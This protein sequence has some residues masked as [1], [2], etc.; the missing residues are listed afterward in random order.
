MLSEQA[1]SLNDP[2]TTSWQNWFRPTN[3]FPARVFGSIVGSLGPEHSSVSPLVCIG[4]PREADGFDI[5]SVAINEH[6]L[7]CS[8]ELCELAALTRGRPFVVAEDLDGDDVGLQ[9]VD[10]LYATVGLRRYRRVW[11]ARTPGSDRLAGAA[12]AYRGPL[13]LN[14]SFLENRCDLLLDP[15]LNPLQTATVARALAGAAAVAYTDFPLARTPTTTD[16]RTAA[17]LVDAGCELIRPYVQSV[18]LRDGAWAWYEH[19]DSFYSRIMRA[20]RRRGLGASVPSQAPTE[21]GPA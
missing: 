15:D 18:W 6:T 14:L 8:G 10:S 9:E 2:S 21:A 12:L 13:G 11:L 16:A 20:H 19:V 17:L 3:R 1:V 7:G 5:G 4:L